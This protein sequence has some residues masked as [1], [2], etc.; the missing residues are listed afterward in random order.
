MM[1]KDF[2]TDKAEVGRQVAGMLGGSLQLTKDFE[3]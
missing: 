2:L 1:K 3:H